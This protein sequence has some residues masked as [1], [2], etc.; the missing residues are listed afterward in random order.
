MVERNTDAP[1]E[2]AEALAQANDQL[3]A[4][5]HALAE[6]LNRAGKELNKARAQL[7][8]LAQP[9]MTFATMVRVDSC[10]TDEYGAGRG[11]LQCGAFGGRQYRALERVD[12]GGRS[13]WSRYRGHGTYHRPGV[14]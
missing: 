14:R 9:P 12:G 4:K 2:S 7:A 1:R 11:Q 6:A 8:Q 5:N 13:A 3:M 10:R